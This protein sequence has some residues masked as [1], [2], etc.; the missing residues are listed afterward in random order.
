MLFGSTVY[1]QS[2][3]THLTPC[4]TAV[5][6]TL[7]DRAAVRNRQVEDVSAVARAA[8]TAN[9]LRT[10]YQEELKQVEPYRKAKMLHAHTFKV[11][12]H[13]CIHI[14]RYD[15]RTIRTGLGVAVYHTACTRA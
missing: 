11:I 4:I 14:R 2:H 5:S 6:H 15:P 3:L 1:S 13:A 8:R 12:E 7:H 10:V 9:Q